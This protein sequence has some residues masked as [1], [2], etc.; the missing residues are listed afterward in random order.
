MIQLIDLNYHVHANISEPIEVMELQKAST[1]FVKFINRKLNLTLVKHMNYEG[2]IS[3]YGTACNFFKRR[4]SFFGIPFKTHRFIK[5]QSPD[6]ILIQGLIFPAQIIALKMLA[7]RKVKFIVQHHGE[8]PYRGIKKIFQQ[9][10]DRSIHKYIFTSIVNANE[11]IESGIISSKEKC[12]EVLEASTDFNQRDK[13]KSKQLLG[14]DGNK[15]FLW[16]GRLHTGKDPLTVINAFEKYISTH[17]EGKLYMVYQTNELLPEIEK[18]LS[19]NESLQ[20]AVV[21]LGKV[22]HDDLETWYN[23]ADFYISGSHKEGSGYALIEAMACG[24]IP[25]VTKIPSFNKITGNGKFG[26]LFEPGSSESLLETLVKLNNVNRNEFAG[27]VV[28]HFK[29]SLSFESIA[30]SLYEVCESTL[31]Q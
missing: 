31:I 6:I 8:S 29:N 14:M 27:S 26:F 11:W 16:V 21:L 7:G 23:A 24:C 4:N 20:N 25:V 13:E 22:F 17:P 3:L 5:K 28:N 10:A 19:K 1:G 12:S 18:E 2:E 15:N 9:T 30:N